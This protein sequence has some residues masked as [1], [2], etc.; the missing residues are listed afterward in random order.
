MAEDA[1]ALTTYDPMPSNYQHASVD[2]LSFSNFTVFQGT[3]G[4][5]AASCVPS[6]D[7][8]GEMHFG[9][10]STNKEIGMWPEREI[11]W[12]SGRLY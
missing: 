4:V 2:R 8:A 3:P 1:V 6:R 9:N 10:G 11:T 5:K 12:E 7:E